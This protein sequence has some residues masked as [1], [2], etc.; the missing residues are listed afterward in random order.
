MRSLLFLFSLCVARFVQTRPCRMSARSH[1]VCLRVL[2]SDAWLDASS[3]F[4][5]LSCTRWSLFQI[6]FAKVLPTI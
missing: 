6:S 4:S 5:A 1:K 2:H 3:C